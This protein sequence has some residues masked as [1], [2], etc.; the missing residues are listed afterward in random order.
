MEDLT[1]QTGELQPRTVEELENMIRII[2]EEI[3]REGSNIK[4]DKLE[5]LTQKKGVMLE[6]RA[7]LKGETTDDKGQTSFS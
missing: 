3:V 2:D 1:K 6:E 5:M 4:Q 7:R